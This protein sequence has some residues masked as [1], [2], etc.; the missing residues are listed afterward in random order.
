M[1]VVKKG[2]AM[3]DQDM[4]GWEIALWVGAGLSL[5]TV[6]VGVGFGIVVLFYSQRFF[7]FYYHL[8]DL[9]HPLIWLG[10]IATVAFTA[11]A[12]GQRNARKNQK[13]QQARLREWQQKRGGPN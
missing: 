5:I 4:D 6:G 11:L 1:S 9:P 2:E 7:W 13:E 3:Q 10:L 12:I 8:D